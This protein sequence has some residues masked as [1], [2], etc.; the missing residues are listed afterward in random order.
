MGLPG[1]IE[2]VRL[3]REH[4]KRAVDAVTHA[5]V[6]DPMWSCVLPDREAR[7]TLLR[8]MW[9]ALASF[10]RVYGEAWT[11][12]DGAGAALWIRPGKTKT[13]LWMMVRTGLALPRSMI[14]LPKE[15][16]DRFFPMM[17]FIDGLH[18]ELM[19]GPHWYL[20]V[21]GV[22]PGRQGRGIGR[23]LLSPGLDL[24][25][26]DGV[27]CYLE[28]QTTGNVEFY[29]KSGFEVIREEREPVCGLPIWL[30]QR[31]PVRGVVGPKRKR[32]RWAALRTS[33]GSP[34]PIRR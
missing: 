6:D 26:R 25:D 24:A 12:S 22:D 21:L 10:S 31:S 33:E 32:G 5:F 7:G 14:G 4:Q 3:D 27:S 19:P 11:T 18:K 13:T 2:I 29:K 28:T 23:R 34:A 20:W 17:R 9:N 16:R 15:A 1:E 30:M 8:P